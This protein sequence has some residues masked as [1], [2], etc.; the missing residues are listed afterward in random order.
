MNVSERLLRLAD[1]NFQ[2]SLRVS[3]ESRQVR[4]LKLSRSRWASVF[5]RK[6]YFYFAMLRVDDH[7]GPSGIATNGQFINTYFI[8]SVAAVFGRLPEIAFPHFIKVH[9]GFT[10]VAAGSVF[11]TLKKKFIAWVSYL[12]LLNATISSWI[13]CFVIQVQ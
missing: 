4:Q 8:H 9:S 12:V 3:F 2:N 5:S 11:H 1:E 13:Y 6:G 10:S 7:S